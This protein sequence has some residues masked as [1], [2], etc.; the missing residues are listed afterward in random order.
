MA[1]DLLSWSQVS[2]LVT[3]ERASSVFYGWGH[4]IA[5]HSGILE[6][7]PERQKEA[8][9]TARAAMGM[10]KW[11]LAPTR[12]GLQQTVIRAGFS[13]C[14]ILGDLHAFRAKDMRTKDVEEGLSPIQVTLD[15]A[16]HL[17]DAVA[18]GTS[19]GKT[20]AAAVEGSGSIAADDYFRSWDAA[21][22]ELANKYRLGGYPEIADFI[23]SMW[24]C[25]HFCFSYFN[26]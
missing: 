17:M 6:S 23:L 15:Q 8:K 26:Y 11:T 18:L 1:D 13:D 19:A 21:R 16:A 25:V 20:T 2:A 12:E 10:P 3:C 24:V 7:I 22:S 14:A 4:P 5:Y 9:D